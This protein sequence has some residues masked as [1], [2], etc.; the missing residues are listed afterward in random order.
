MNWLKKA[1]RKKEEASEIKPA[2]APA[3]QRGR[4]PLKE[5]F[6]RKLIEIGMP[7]GDILDVGA[8]TATYELLRVFP[9]RR[10]LLMEP[11][12]EWNE[13]M[14]RNYSQAGVSFEIINAAIS[15][16]DGEVRLKTTSVRSGESITHARMASDGDKSEGMR[17]VP[18]RTLDG[19]VAERTLEK[20]YL[21]KIDVDGAELSVL[22]GAKNTLKD[23]SVVVI[24]TGIANMI[25][26]AQAVK[27]AGF[28]VFDIVD[29]S[30]YDGRFVQA[31]IVFVNEKILNERKL[32]VYHHGFDIKK[33]R[34]YVPA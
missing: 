23:C 20:P 3:P 15:D 19:L 30:Y 34:N 9:D 24:E 16:R 22:A 28:Q 33:W 5:D 32:G 6:F 26:R 21:L 4:H 1:F 25:E 18:M 27:D 11:I 31:D 2:P 12:V 17:V 13:G 10:H 14:E 8:K 7:I 29:I